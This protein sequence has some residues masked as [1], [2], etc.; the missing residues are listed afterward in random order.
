M[1]VRAGT[2]DG[3]EN[4]HPPDM[5]RAKTGARPNNAAKKT[6]AWW[7]ADS[8]S[9]DAEEYPHARRAPLGGGNSFPTRRLKVR[10]DRRTRHRYDITTR[11]QVSGAAGAPK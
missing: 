8:D 4:P 1:D 5:V 7:P 9:S 10:A 3:S 2:G 6:C 11:K